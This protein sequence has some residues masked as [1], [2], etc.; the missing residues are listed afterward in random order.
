MSKS[1]ISPLLLIAIRALFIR[2]MT[3]QRY[4]DHMSIGLYTGLI[5]AQL[6]M[7]TEKLLFRLLMQKTNIIPE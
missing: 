1:E 7:R 3:H 6:D 5:I 2:P 4:L